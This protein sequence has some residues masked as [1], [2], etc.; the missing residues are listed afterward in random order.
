MLCV[1]WLYYFHWSALPL[2]TTNFKI[3]ATDDPKTPLYNSSFE[4]NVKKYFERKPYLNL[5]Q[6]AFPT[7]R[8]GFKVGMKLEG[9][10]PRHPSLYCVLSIAEVRGYRIRL[11]FDGYS[12]CHDF[13]VNASSVDIFPLGWCEKN[14]KKLQVPKGKQEKNA[15][16]LI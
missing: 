12:E 9:I 11:H 2:Q 15:I 13:W 10:D 1:A 14:N 4:L 5:Q 8:N 3:P 7:N 6:P 16:I